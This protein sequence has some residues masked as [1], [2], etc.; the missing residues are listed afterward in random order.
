MV[1]NFWYRHL[2]HVHPVLAK[3]MQNIINNPELTPSFVLKKITYMLPTEPDAHSP[4]DIRPIACIQTI[5]KLLTTII[6]DKVYTHCGLNNIL[7]EEQ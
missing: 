6:S 7:T 2:T 5:Y 3:C 1:H 4:S